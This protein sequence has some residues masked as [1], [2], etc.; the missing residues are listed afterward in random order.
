MALSRYTSCLSGE[1][2][3]QDCGTP[4]HQRREGAG[5][6]GQRVAVPYRV[7]KAGRQA[8][9]ES[10][11]W[12]PPEGPVTRLRQ[13]RSAREGTKGARGPV[14]ASHAMRMKQSEGV[15]VVRRARRRCHRGG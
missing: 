3:Q 5:E 1:I 2:K 12:I 8:V 4:K 11:T 7:H 13:G 10:F 15:V 14:F 6:G 9:D